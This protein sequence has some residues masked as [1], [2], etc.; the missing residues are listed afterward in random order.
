MK[1]M[2]RLAASALGTAALTVANPVFAQDQVE[3]TMYY[4]IAVGGP[5]T[6]VIDGIVEDFEAENPNVSV[7]AIYA[8]NYDDTRVRA[9]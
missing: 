3:L 8:G 1:T 6:E 7:E 4:P 9:L 2:T 5:L